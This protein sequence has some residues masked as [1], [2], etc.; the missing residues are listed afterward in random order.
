MSCSSLSAH[1]RSLAGTCPG[2]ALGAQH[3]IQACHGGSP[4]HLAKSRKS[5]QAPLSSGRGLLT[6]E[7]LDLL[8][9]GEELTHPM[10][11]PPCSWF[12]SARRVW[13]PRERREKHQTPKPCQVC[14]ER[15]GRQRQD[16][17]RTISLPGVKHAC[18]LKELP[19]EC[20]EGS[21]PVAGSEERLQAWP[22]EV[23]ADGSFHASQKLTMFSFSL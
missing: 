17:T 11:S 20:F 23:G 13:T 6:R 14:S 8:C 4:S 10:T 16:R 15:K 19:A 12:V 2:T 21:P 9:F 18:L 3:H 5:S 22:G 1:G 7:A